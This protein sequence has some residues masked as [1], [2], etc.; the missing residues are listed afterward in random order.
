MN[1]VKALF[2][3]YFMETM[4]IAVKSIKSLS[5]LSEN[6]QEKLLNLQSL[7]KVEYLLSI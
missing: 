7:E 5:L 1:S 3:K 4:F 6:I 2:I